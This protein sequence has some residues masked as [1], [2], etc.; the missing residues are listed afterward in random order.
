MPDTKLDIL[1]I[2]LQNTQKNSYGIDIIF[3][4]LQARKLKHRTLKEF[5]WDQMLVIGNAG[6]Q[7]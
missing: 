5:A 1:H 4:N 2:L 3:I 6:I 7:N